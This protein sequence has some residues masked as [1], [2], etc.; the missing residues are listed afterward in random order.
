MDGGDGVSWQLV[1]EAAYKAWGSE[2]TR[3]SLQSWTLKICNLCATSE[4]T[5]LFIERFWSL[6]PPDISCVI[7]TIHV[8][9]I[10]MCCNCFI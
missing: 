3:I 2:R 7:L 9:E 8:L 6:C 10:V 4:L 1:L 5:L